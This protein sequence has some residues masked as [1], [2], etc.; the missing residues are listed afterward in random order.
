VLGREVS[1]EFMV[2]EEMLAIQAMKNAVTGENSRDV[3]RADSSRHPTEN[4]NVRFV[5]DKVAMGRI[6]LR[7]FRFSPVNIIPLLVT[8]HSCII[9]GLENLSNSGPV[10][11]RQRIKQ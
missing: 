9:L 6:F 2:T 8:N 1:A 4:V 5:V 11:Q 3:A 7:D 10:P